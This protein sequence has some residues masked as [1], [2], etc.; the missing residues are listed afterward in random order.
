MENRIRVTNTGNIV[1]TGPSTTIEVLDDQGEWVD[2]SRCVT[3][4]RWDVQV[5]EVSLIGLSLIPATADISGL[6]DEKTLAAFAD[7]LRVRGW[8]VE[9]KAEAAPVK[10]RRFGRR[11]GEVD[12]TVF[13]SKGREYLSLPGL[14]DP[15]GRKKITVQI[16]A[17]TAEMRA[18]VRRE[19]QRQSDRWIRISR[20]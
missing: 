20:P 3:G 10:R 9:R 5:G 13:G 12:V 18:I 19:L 6:A 1:G 16:S 2:I 17:D 7:V 15:A 11:R 8:S 14:K 4:V